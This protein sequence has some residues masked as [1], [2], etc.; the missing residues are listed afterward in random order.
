MKI[1]CTEREKENLLDCID[2]SNFCPISERC[3]SNKSCRECA[4]E[5]IEWVVED[6]KW[7]NMI[8]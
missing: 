8:R 3:V 2:A 1:I 7:I 4:E 6:K 5:H